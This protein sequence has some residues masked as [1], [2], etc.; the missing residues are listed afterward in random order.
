MGGK[1]TAVRVASADNCTD[2]F[3]KP[4]PAE[5]FARH[6]AALCLVDFKNFESSLEQP[7]Q[8]A[9]AF[10]PQKI[11]QSTTSGLRPCARRAMHV[12][13]N[14]PE[15]T[16]QLLVY[17]LHACSRRQQGAVV[18]EASSSSSGPARN[19]DYSDW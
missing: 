1:L 8:V 9:P 10:V 3:T 6:R 19:S 18:S 11:E 4:L 12:V 5:P 7:K 14:N 13:Q 17:I 15:E 2:R 16:K